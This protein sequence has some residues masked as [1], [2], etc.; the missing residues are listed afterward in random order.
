MTVPNPLK[1]DTRIKTGRRFIFAAFQ[2]RAGS[3]RTTRKPTNNRHNLQKETQLL[4]YA[5]DID[6]VG[7]SQSAVRNAYYLALEREAAKVE[8][9]INEQ[10]TKYMI[11]PGIIRDVG[12]SVVIGDY[13]FE[14]VKEF[15]YLGSLMTPVNDVSLEVQRIIHTANRCF[16]KLRKHLQTSHLERQTKYTIH[17]TL[18]RSVLLYGSETWLLTKREENQLLVFDRKVLRTICGPKIENDVY[19]RRYNHELDKEFDSLNALNVTK[20]SRLRYAGHMI[21]RPEDLSKKALFRAKP[22]RRRNQGRPK[23]RWVDGVNSDSLALGVRDWTH[24]WL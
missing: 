9:K 20:T 4:A 13:H 18:I 15:V 21:K 22:N 24:Y 23:A 3:Y 17:K 5:D 10:K 8:F 1:P 6:I 7:R 16:F 2:C 14:V 11:G 19:R 12:Q